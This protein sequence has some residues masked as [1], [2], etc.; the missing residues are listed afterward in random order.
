MVGRRPVLSA[1]FPTPT[2]TVRQCGMVIP[3]SDVGL[4]VTLPRLEDVSSGCW[5]TVIATY[6]SKSIFVTPY[7]TDM[8]RG[9]CPQSG[10]AVDVVF[11]GA[12][13][14]D[15]R[16]PTT[17]IGDYINIVAVPQETASGNTVRLGWYVTG[18][19]GVWMN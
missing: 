13:A 18:C 16:D 6:A 11:T 4:N 19:N 15:V 7:A 5:Y 12:A 1:A 14:D 9:K 10:A 2:V 17:A 3:V 8:I